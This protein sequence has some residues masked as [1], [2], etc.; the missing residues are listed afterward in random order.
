MPLAGT[1][2]LSFLEKEGSILGDTPHLAE[3]SMSIA[4][5]QV[6]PGSA[7]VAG[8]ALAKSMKWLECIIMP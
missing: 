3:N 8:E 5:F 4:H 1:Y 6:V 7:C 2:D